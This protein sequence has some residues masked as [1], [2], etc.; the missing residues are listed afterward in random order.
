MEV[1]YLERIAKNTD[2]KT[3]FQII[4]SSDKSNFNTRFNPKLEL[5]EEKYTRLLL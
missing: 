3:S 5:D 2:H 1:E 4:L